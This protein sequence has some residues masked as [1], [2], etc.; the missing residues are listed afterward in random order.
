MADEPVKATGDAATPSEVG[1]AV[2]V[3]TTG[4]R[5]SVGKDRVLVAS[6]RQ[7]V[8]WRFRRHKLAMVGAVV[9][10]AFYLVAIFA[11]FLAYA[12]PNHT[13]GSRVLIPPQQS[14]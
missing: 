12:E 1:A 14:M 11:D 9:I 8:W 2:V 13:N 7:L 5:R 3:E 4:G 10:I 6:Q